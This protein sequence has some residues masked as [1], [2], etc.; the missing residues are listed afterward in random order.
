VELKIDS[1]KKKWTAELNRWE[2]EM[3]EKIYQK[4]S[5]LQIDLD[6]FHE[7]MQTREDYCKKFLVDRLETKFNHILT[8]E[9]QQTESNVV[10]A[11]KEFV[12]LQKT[13]DLLNTT[14]LID[15]QNVEHNQLHFDAPSLFFPR[16][17]VDG[18]DWMKNFSTESTV[19]IMEYTNPDEVDV[20]EN[21]NYRNT[22][23]YALD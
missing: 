17:N 5:E 22:G 9:L 16:V 4:R 15:M 21:T 1:G 6:H 14:S 18:F 7:Q 2:Q 19:E 11:E 12:R 8:E 13:F 23:N 20:E 3:H 10:E